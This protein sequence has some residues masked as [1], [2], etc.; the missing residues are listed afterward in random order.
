[1]QIYDTGSARKRMKEPEEHR[2]ILMFS[3]RMLQVFGRFESVHDVLVLCLVRLMACG[4]ENMSATCSGLLVQWLD[5]TA[6]ELQGRFDTMAETLFRDLRYQILQGICSIHENPGACYRLSMDHTGKSN[7]TEPGEL[8]CIEATASILGALKAFGPSMLYDKA[9]S[10]WR[11]RV[12]R[13]FLPAL[14]RQARA[15]LGKDKPPDEW[16]D[17]PGFDSFVNEIAEEQ[18]VPA[19]N[20][21]NCKDKCIRQGLGGFVTEPAAELGNL[22][23]YYKAVRAQSLVL[24][25]RTCPERTLHTRPTG[26]IT[27]KTEAA[28]DIDDKKNE[29]WKA[30]EN[31][32]TVL[33]IATNDPSNAA[34]CVTE[35]KVHEAV[36]RHAIGP[37]S[38]SDEL[39]LKSLD[40]SR[41][42]TRLIQLAQNL[43]RA[44]GKAGE[45]VAKYFLQN[46]LHMNCWTRAR[47]RLHEGGSPLPIARLDDM[48]AD[49]TALI[50]DLVELVNLMS[51]VPTDGVGDQTMKDLEQ[52]L[53][54]FEML[55]EIAASNFQPDPLLLS[56]SYET[57]YSFL[58]NDFM[59]H[60]KMVHVV[61]KL[62]ESAILLPYIRGKSLNDSPNEKYQQLWVK[63]V[64]KYGVDSRL[65]DDLKNMYENPLADEEGQ[66]RELVPEMRQLENSM[67]HR[68]ILGIVKLIQLFSKLAVNDL[69]GCLQAVTDLLDDAGRE[70]LLIGPTTGLT[71]C[72]DY[73]IRVES[74]RCIRHVL[75]ASPGQFTLEEMGWTLSF[76]SPTGLGVGKQ[77]IFL[78]EVIELIKVFVRNESKTGHAFRVKFAKYA[79]RESF[80]ML[81]ANS[82]RET[83]G[84]EEEEASRAAF[85]AKITELLLDCS[86]PIY[87]DAGLRRFLHRVDLLAT[88]TEI[89]QQSEQLSPNS[90]DLRILKTW[91][92]R[93]VRQVLMPIITGTSFRIHGPVIHAALARLGDVIQ[94][95]P[96]H[97][98]AD[99][100]K[101]VP[102]TD[103]SNFWRGTT[104]VHD[105]LSQHDT[106]EREDMIAQQAQFMSSYGLVSLLDFCERYMIA[107]DDF[108]S[109]FYKCEQVVLKDF[110]EHTDTEI[111]NA[112]SNVE[113][114]ESNVRTEQSKP[115]AEGIRLDDQIRRCFEK[116]LDH[117]KGQALSLFGCNLDQYDEK[118]DEFSLAKL[119]KVYMKYWQFNENRHDREV[120][121]NARA[122]RQVLGIQDKYRLA[123]QLHD[124]QEAHKAGKEIPKVR[125]P[126]SD[127]EKLMVEATEAHTL[128]KRILC[129]PKDANAGKWCSARTDSYDPPSKLSSGLRD[130]LQ[131][132]QATAIDTGIQARTFVESQSRYKY[133]GDFSR[134]TDLSTIILEFPDVSRLVKAHQALEERA[135][136]LFIM[137][138]KNHF[139]IPTVLGEYYLALKFQHQLKDGGMHYSELRLCL[140]P[141]PHDSVTNSRNLTK[142]VETILQQKC[143][144]LRDTDL[145]AEFLSFSMRRRS[146][147]HGDLVFLRNT[148]DQNLEVNQQEVFAQSNNLSSCQLFHIERVAGHG[149]IKSGDVV[150]LKSTSR[151]RYLDVHPSG[152]VRCALDEDDPDRDMRF[153]IEAAETGDEPG[154]IG[155]LV[156]VGSSTRSPSTAKRGLHGEKIITVESKLRL[157]ILGSNRYITVSRKS[158]D[159]L[160]LSG[161]RLPAAA[162]TLDKHDRNDS[163]FSIYRNGAVTLNLSALQ[164]SKTMVSIRS[165]NTIQTIPEASSD[166]IL[167]TS[168]VETHMRVSLSVN[169]MSSV[170][171]GPFG[172]LPQI[173]Q[174]MMQNISGMAEKSWH[175]NRA[176]NKGLSSKV[177]WEDAAETVAGIVRC[178]YMLL[179]CPV[180]T[181]ARPYVVNIFTERLGREAQLLRLISMVSTVQVGLPCCRGADESDESAADVDAA[182]LPAKLCRLLA[183]GLNNVPASQGADVDETEIPDRVT[184]PK[185]RERMEKDFADVDRER[186]TVLGVLAAYTRRMVVHPL[187]DKLAVFHQKPLSPQAVVLLSE[188]ATLTNAII[189]GIH[190]NEMRCVPSSMEEAIGNPSQLEDTTQE[191][192]KEVQAIEQVADAT[193]A[194]DAEA[195]PEAI[196]D[197][198]DASNPAP[199]AQSS[200]RKTTSRALTEE[201]RTRVVRELL[202]PITVKALLHTMLYGIH[203]EAIAFRAGSAGASEVSVRI[204]SGLVD[205]SIQALASLMDL[206]GASSALTGD[207]QES[208]GKAVSC[209][210][211]ICEAISQAMTD[212]T[213]LV[214]RARIAQLHAERSVDALRLVLDQLIQDG[215]LEASGG[216]FTTLGGGR[217]YQTERVRSIAYA[218]VGPVACGSQIQNSPKRR[219]VMTTSRFRMAVIRVNGDSVVPS[220]SDLRVESVR[221]M[222]NIQRS[223]FSRKMHQFVGLMWE[224]LDGFRNQTEVLVFESSGRKRIFQQALQ[225]VP[226]TR[227]REK[228]KSG[229]ASTVNSQGLQLSTCGILETALRQEVE[230]TLE[231]SSQVGRGGAPLVSMTFVR[232]PSV[233][234]MEPSVDLLILTRGSIAVISMASFLSR[235]ARA[236]DFNTYA[237]G[238]RVIAVDTDSEDDMLA[239]FRELAAFSSD[240]S[241]K[242][243]V[244]ENYLFNL[245]ELQGVWFVAEAKPKVRL[246]F[247]STTEIN[248]ISD[249]ERQRFR[250]HLATV[251][252]EEAQGHQD[253]K[254]QAWT[255]IPT[256]KTDLKAIEQ[257]TRTQATGTLL[258]LPSTSTRT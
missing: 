58:E 195:E 257:Q 238:S 79:I 237:T 41:A 225:K 142:H 2:A 226:R 243:E 135:T 109:Y 224:E 191:V 63:C 230:D 82:R 182:W 146:L 101:D 121:D 8:E 169:Q 4:S 204:I 210:Y 85:A 236:E 113:R 203:Q 106:V 94:G 178:A 32:L 9:V 54:V 37:D 148:D 123:D 10:P 18:E 254:N 48:S 71:T 217:K 208:G 202:P 19:E 69:T 171:G 229:A 216:M 76:L 184:N 99:T 86:R 72:P 56:V 242:C 6:V 248:F 247:G 188:F 124:M 110:Y 245:E 255:V 65:R 11:A 174:V 93:D 38:L 144:I 199:S 250:R 167:R 108:N 170:E 3:D 43:I 34:Q 15:E 223:I 145:V 158:G 73:N 220:L 68:V 112:W 175:A 67:M 159:F 183:Q 61:S 134:C 221:D 153:V 253:K 78:M 46:R 89:L 88:L 131:A 172:R 138:V 151:K 213:Q 26:R 214:P 173:I 103:E 227:D 23:V 12:L 168:L 29:S 21:D 165:R 161:D 70:K 160:I 20:L 206:T 232:S 152:H 163:I 156:P 140:S 219:I 154:L 100:F 102:M 215:E 75:E 147:C 201:A 176:A 25:R 96:D 45:E 51:Q 252:A 55:L 115:V 111:R 59:R 139:S 164:K 104:H 251:L 117:L 97:E 136:N 27:R 137:Q 212:G 119:A 57:I 185:Q 209:S 39:L 87:P 207:F 258:A 200:Q 122:I 17:Y 105:A 50:A 198:V 13:P 133:Y 244:L 127:L 157:K 190:V 240:E 62:R 187:L 24:L 22:K 194:D 228:G 249:G 192:S 95:K 40:A 114:L 179:E 91:T 211:D 239:P 16:A 129:I 35:F 150:L 130:F 186:V 60:K 81:S 84:K 107:D 162:E 47:R 98:H 141:N 155:G 132:N 235:F 74:L 193:E 5:A 36:V 77:E 128:M 28:E 14:C 234:T 218:F 233:D 83:H 64:L 231:E 181:G 7:E 222:R 180:A 66:W 33:V 149:A 143:N 126:H 80:E 52:G 53:D 49:T 189:N 166:E 125:Q 1:M 205:K 256:N 177:S 120:Q 196:A 197:I 246:Q 90:L 118:R 116:H 42:Y 241:G 92:G 44:T 30:W 31:C